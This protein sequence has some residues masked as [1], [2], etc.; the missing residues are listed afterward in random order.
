MSYYVL[1]MAFGLAQSAF[2]GHFVC[3]LCKLWAF[4]H[5]AFKRTVF[6][7]HFHLP[8]FWHCSCIKPQGMFCVSHLLVRAFETLHFVLPS[9]TAKFS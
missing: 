5:F 6:P 2:I 1:R 4:A 8:S 7:Y 3:S 9:K